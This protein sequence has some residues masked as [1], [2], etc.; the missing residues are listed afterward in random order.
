[1]LMFFLIFFNVLILFN[2]NVLKKVKRPVSCA[3]PV[4]C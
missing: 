4:D 3:V 2:V 1:M